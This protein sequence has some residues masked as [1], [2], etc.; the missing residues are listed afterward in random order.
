MFLPRAAGSILQLANNHLSLLIFLI[1]ELSA[2]LNDYVANSDFISYPVLYQSVLW[3][4]SHNSSWVLFPLGDDPKDGKSV[5]VSVPLYIQAR[6]R[7]RH[8]ET[9]KETEKHVIIM[10]VRKCQ[11]VGSSKCFSELLVVTLLELDFDT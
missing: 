8:K 5:L 9:K 1:A 11:T 7:E 6:K 2:G 10:N 3:G 4:R